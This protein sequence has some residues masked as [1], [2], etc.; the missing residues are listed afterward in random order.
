MG[1]TSKEIDVMIIPHVDCDLALTFHEN[2]KLTTLGSRAY[3]W[4]IEW[5]VSQEYFVRRMSVAYKVYPQVERI[6]LPRVE[7]TAGI[8]LE[9]AIRTRRT[10][11]SFS[12]EGVTLVDLARLL[13]HSYGITGSIPIPRHPDLV[14]D[15]RAVPSAGALY[16]LEIYL[17]TFRVEGA[18]PGLYHYNVL[19]HSLE[20]IKSGLFDEELGEICFL[21]PYI[22][23]DKSAFMMLISCVFNRALFKYQDRG[24]RF[25]LLEAGHVAQNV[26]LMCHGMG[27]GSVLIGGF[28]DDQL[29]EL[30]GLDGYHESVIYP[31][32]IGKP[33]KALDR[34]ESDAR[35]SSNC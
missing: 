32:V 22:E 9:L 15:L 6:F 16:P 18:R 5:I 31:I 7:D 26:S 14:Q 27:L 2:T 1:R 21:K 24:Y 12:G 3:G 29:N 20:L 4:Q 17:A 19:E 23:V 25:I 11:R 35:T 34:G 13:F 28:L 10:V 8:D 30:F 33:Q